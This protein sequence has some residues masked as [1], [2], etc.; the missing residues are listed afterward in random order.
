MLKATEAEKLRVMTV[1][2]GEMLGHG[3]DIKEL[4]IHTTHSAAH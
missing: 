2:S 4:S 1:S 3:C